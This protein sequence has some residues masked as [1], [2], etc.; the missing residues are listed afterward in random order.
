[1]ER[2]YTRVLA[3]ARHAH[4]V[5]GAIPGA[6]WDLSY[7]R[8]A[9]VDGAARTSMVRCDSDPNFRNFSR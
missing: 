7:G 3:L 8:L 1:M 5:K 4:F 6:R 2:D 9:G